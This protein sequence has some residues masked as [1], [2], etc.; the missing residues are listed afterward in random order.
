MV[1]G[2]LAKS[3]GEESKNDGGLVT[4]SKDKGTGEPF[5]SMLAGCGLKKGVQ[6]R[7]AAIKGGAV[8]LTGKRRYFKH[9]SFFL[10]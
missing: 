3:K 1:C 5:F 6:F 8:V 9:R 10:C 2:D 7:N 4:F